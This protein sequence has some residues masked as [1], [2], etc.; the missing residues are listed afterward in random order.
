[1]K[2]SIVT[3]GGLALAEIPRSTRET[4]RQLGSGLLTALMAF[5]KEVH[6]AELQSLNFHDRTVTF[7][8]VGEFFVVAEITSSAD[9]DLSMKILSGIKVRAFNL[10]K[11]QSQTTISVLEAES[12]VD[13]LGS[14]DWINKTLASLG[15]KKPLADAEIFQITLRQE[16]GN[17]I[18]DPVD[19]KYKEISVAINNL[20][21]KGID[22]SGTPFTKLK[23]FVPISNPPCA[24]YL[25]A[26]LKESIIEV[27]LIKIDIT[28]NHTLFRLVP[29][30][31]REY[32]VIRS[33]DSD[34]SVIQLLNQLKETHDYTSR[35]IDIGAISLNFLEKNVT[36]NLDKTI[37][38]VVIGERVA[39][40][41]D[42]PSVRI[43][44]NSLALFAQHRATDIVE[45]LEE[46]RIGHNITGMSPSKYS[47]LLKNKQIDKSIPTIMLDSGQVTGGESNKFI[48]NLFNNVKKKGLNDAI[49]II[50][51]K[52]E[53]LVS[54]ALNV[55]T[56]VMITKEEAIKKLSQ[57]KKD[58]NNNSKFDLIMKLAK[59]RNPLLEL[60][61]NEL[62]T[63]LKSA[64]D[65]L[66]DF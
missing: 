5:S 17:C 64:E 14:L 60:I 36:K 7:L 44:T 51:Q 56:L 46:D 41:G 28:A 13:Q 12:I 4:H 63:S 49:G 18:I 59:Q 30:I 47:S 54:Y 6:K 33:L 20:I 3:K 8:P 55:T 27:N 26:I 45:W 15:Y 2:L 43:V 10:L 39:V 9:S 66:A 31:D 16:N 34:K 25:V 24:V 11:E 32:E 50:H 52:L 48:K 61:I 22:L 62:S 21:Q 42:K 38:S 58:I 40:V 35:K 37:Y 23:A 57:L 1:M 19:K 65:Y 29:V 53:S